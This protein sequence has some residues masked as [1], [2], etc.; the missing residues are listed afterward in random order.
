M[1]PTNPDSDAGGP[2]SATPPG[3][4]GF[5]RGLKTTIDFE[6]EPPLPAPIAA[7]DHQDLRRR[8]RETWSVSFRLETVLRLWNNFNALLS[9]RLSIDDSSQEKISGLFPGLD[10]YQDVLTRM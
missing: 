9:M 8:A 5:P 10:K 6:D 4:G 3:W 7:I 1:D 2:P